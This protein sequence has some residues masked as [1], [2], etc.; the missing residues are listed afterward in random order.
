MHIDNLGVRQGRCFG[1]LRRGQM[2]FFGEPQYGILERR[3]DVGAK[4]VF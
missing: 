1:E 2:E 4:R 3:W